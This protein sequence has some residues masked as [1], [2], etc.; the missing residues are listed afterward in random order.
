MK[1]REAEVVSSFDNHSQER[2]VVLEVIREL[3]YFYQTLQEPRDLARLINRLP[4]GIGASFFR[5]VNEDLHTDKFDGISAAEFRQFLVDEY[6]REHE[7]NERRARADFYALGK[8]MAN[9]TTRAELVE[10]GRRRAELAPYT[11]VSYVYTNHCWKCKGPISSAIHAR[12][13]S[14]GWYICTCGACGCGNLDDPR[15]DFS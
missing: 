15:A 4:G 9:A 8:E 6:R 7:E 14:C 12:C 11:G 13:S 3:V 5:Q 1:T 10:L 2:E